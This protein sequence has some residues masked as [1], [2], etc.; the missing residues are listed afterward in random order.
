MSSFLISIRSTARKKSP[1]TLKR[2]SPALNEISKI[3]AALKKMSV[4]DL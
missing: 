2:P 4:G 1:E 3:A